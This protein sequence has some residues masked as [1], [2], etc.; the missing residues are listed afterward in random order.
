MLL[1]EN[2]GSPGPVDGAERV[3]PDLPAGI[4][5]PQPLERLRL[6]VYLGQLLTDGAMLLAG[7]ALATWI[8][9]G[10]AY[11]D[12]VWGSAQLM[13]PL[14]WTVALLNRSY[15]VGAL[16]EPFFGLQR[17]L[18][19]LLLSGALVV[20]VLFLARSSL[21]LSRF[22]FGL[23]CIAAAMLIAW[24]RYNLSPMVRRLVGDSASNILVID[25]GGPQ[26][27]LTGSL[28][29]DAKVY[30]LE[31][32]LDDPHLLNLLAK[33]IAPMD[34]VIIS[35]PPKARGAWA[36]LLKG[37]HIAGEIVAEEVETLGI[38]GSR[39]TDGVATFVV[40]AAPLGLRARVL[41]RGL[42]LAIAVPA[43]IVLAL[44]LLLIAILIKLEDG[45]AALFRQLRVG[46]NNRFF[47]IYKF[48]TMR[49]SASDG[50]GSRSTARD[51][52]RLTRLGPWLRRSSIDEL[53]Q[54]INVVRG[55]MSLVG[56]RP[57]AL[58]SQ[59]GE[60]LFWEVDDRYWQ[61]HALK[62]G[63]SGLAQVRGLR[64]STQHEQDLTARLQADLEYQD[65]WTLW[66]DIVIML[67]TLGVLVHDRA[68]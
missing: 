3:G 16:V 60:K 50:Q 47:Q 5:L 27:N 44:P 41:K 61:R 43:L 66:R 34:R 64:G 12:S 67:R 9:L 42:D 29:V 59:A 37:S 48:R 20:V 8:Y 17:T 25:A 53:P 55:E 11:H 63:M 33:L 2:V 21:E 23:G 54:L 49:L 45:G 1:A 14:F 57:H 58:G 31:P 56:P 26:V 10:D 46:R 19:A 24:A 39:R 38:F 40:A 35:C 13:L 18:A 65:G 52:D 15:S 7:F 32:R 6:Q 36:R 62:P 30:G 28:V 4:V 68:F 22:G 51:D